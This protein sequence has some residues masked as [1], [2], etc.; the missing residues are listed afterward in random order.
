MED[1]VRA[2][3]VES[4]SVVDPYSLEDMTRALKEAD[5]ACRSEGGGVAAIISRHPCL[6]D[7]EVEEK[8]ERSGWKYRR[9]ASAAGSA[10]MISSAG[11]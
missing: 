8:K 10:Q 2:S 3:G 5:K 1:L 11:H 7:Q 6:M 4:L 9:T